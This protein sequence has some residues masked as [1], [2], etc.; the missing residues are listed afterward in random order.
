MINEASWSKL[1]SKFL[2]IETKTCIP[3]FWERIV[4]GNKAGYYD[5]KNSQIWWTQE[6]KKNNHKEVFLKAVQ[7]GNTARFND[8]WLEKRYDSQDKYWSGERQYFNIFS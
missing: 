3:N 1:N 5:T 4:W 6:L 8:E 7:Y 2:K